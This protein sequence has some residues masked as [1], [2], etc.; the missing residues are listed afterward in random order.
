MWVASGYQTLSAG[1]KKL[2]SRLEEPAQQAASARPVLSLLAPYRGYRDRALIDK[3]KR[4]EHREI[5]LSKGILKAV[6]SLQQIFG[7]TPPHIE[8][9]TATRSGPTKHSVVV[10]RGRTAAGE[11]YTVRVTPPTRRSNVGA[12][13][14]VSVKITDTPGGFTR[15]GECYSLSHSPSRRGNVNCSAGLLTIEAQA[16]PRARTVSLRLSGGRRMT[17]RVTIVPS[18]LGGPVGFYYQVV[19]GPSP[20][21]VSLT[22]LGAHGEILRVVKLPRIVEC[23]KHPLKY[24]PGGVRTL[25][26]ESVPQGPAF[27]IVGEAYRYLGHLHFDLGIRVG[28]GS[29]Y[30]FSRERGRSFIAVGGK[31]SPLSP[32]FETVCKPHPYEIV[33]A[34]LAAPRDTVLARSASG[35]TYPLRQVAIPP[36]MHAHGDLVYAALSVAPTELLTR[37]PSGETI[38][39][40][41]LRG[42]ATEAFETCEGEE[43]PS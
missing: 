40:E 18:R 30:T 5:D 34:L 19:R 32:Q 4:L 7:V 33:Y 35:A 21:P 16:D 39:T 15:S 9:T 25:V 8:K 17:S 26:H 24:L 37:T 12:Q 1:T 2:I 27:A 31:P 10:G 42:I 11:R 29:E 22:E 28:A 38:A 3:I 41:R 14:C 23:T 43:E 6:G 20:I 13:V 36:N